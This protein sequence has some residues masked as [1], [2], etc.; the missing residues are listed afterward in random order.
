MNLF[1]NNRLDLYERYPWL[2]ITTTI[3]DY[4]EP[5][6]YD[7]LL[8]EYVFS[9]KTDLQ[10]FDEFLSS[11]TNNNYNAI[12]ALE[13][14][15]GSGRATEVFLNKF[16]DGKV[17]LRLVDL[18]IRML[19]FCRKRFKKTSFVKSDSV[20][21]LSK[22]ND[23]YDVIFSL[24]SFSHSVHQILINQG[25]TSGGRY[26]R[27]TI[28]K[29]IINNMIKGSRLFIIHFDSTSEE[30]EILMSQWKKVFTLY[31]NIEIQSPSKLL[32]DE[33]FEELRK[34]CL[35]NLTLSHHEGEDIDYSSLDEALEIFLNFHMESYF[36]ESPLLPIVVGELT[37]YF[38]NFM[39]N[40][41]VIRIKPG[42]F[43]YNIE[44]I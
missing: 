33:I 7:R 36:N 32:L 40:E 26:V 3:E 39:D 6:Y 11:M 43:T 19:E 4:I 44:K 23:K 24:W 2:K 29:V 14:G 42:C 37:E 38:K 12:N 27:D 22:T 1:N 8:K 13:L 9:G 28:K 41:G 31:N 5:C 21:F 25:V 10:L 16:K 20:E 35:I 34:E 18:S 17:R 30:Q 15:C